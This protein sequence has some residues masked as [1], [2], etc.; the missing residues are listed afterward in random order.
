LLTSSTLLEKTK[1]PIKVL[2]RALF[3]ISLRRNG[4]SAKDLQRISEGADEG[5]A[6][7]ERRRAA[8]PFD[9]VEHEVLA[10]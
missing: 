5:R 7:Q 6:A 10:A 2:F 3:E 1:K 4:I 9:G 8:R